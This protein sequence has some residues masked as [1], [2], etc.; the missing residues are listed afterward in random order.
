MAKKSMV[1]RE[2]KRSKT[3]NRLKATRDSLKKVIKSASDFGERLAAVAKLQKLPRNAS[4]CRQT[5]RCRSCGRPH[6]VY[7]K[8]GLCRICLRQALMRGY[9]PGGHKASW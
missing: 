1:A 9:V 7:R 3:V 5:R 2:K 8:F 4:P 6:A